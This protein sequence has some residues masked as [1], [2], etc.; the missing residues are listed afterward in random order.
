MLFTFGKGD[1]EAFG[2]SP[3][4]HT[5][6]GE[7]TLNV[8]TAFHI[9][10]EAFAQ[11]LECA[12]AV[13]LV[14]GVLRIEESVGHA[15]VVG[16]DYESTR[17]LVKPSDREDIAHLADFRIFLSDTGLDVVLTELR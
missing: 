5:G 13:L 10:P 11:W 4:Y 14:V 6:C 12:Y 3:A 16:Q 9:F 17:I 1:V 8:D 15:T 7:V 2:T